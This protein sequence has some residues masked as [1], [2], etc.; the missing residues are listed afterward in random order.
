M[1]CLPCNSTPSLTASASLPQPGL[2]TTGLP[3]PTSSVSFTTPHLDLS[4]RLSL[5]LSPPRSREL[6]RRRRSLS[7]SLSPRGERSRGERSR[8][9]R[10]LPPAAL[11]AG[12]L[13]LLRERSAAAAAGCERERDLLRLRLRSPPPPPRCSSLGAGERERE[14]PR[15]C[16]A[17][18]GQL[19]LAAWVHQAGTPFMSGVCAIEGAIEGAMKASD[20]WMVVSSAGTA[21]PG[22]IG[23]ATC[24]VTSTSIRA[25][26]RQP[27]A[28]NMP[29]PKLHHD[30]QQAWPLAPSGSLCAPHHHFH[31]AVRRRCGHHGPHCE[32]HHP[33]ALRPPALGC[34]RSQTS[35]HCSM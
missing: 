4:L 16:R 27:A 32:A 7:L 28:S 5:S 21:R 9:E 17:G 3:S 8:G 25:S 22:Q 19:G 20:G 31:A 29:R 15:S 10:L 26:V 35:L 13:L 12:D 18:E 14:R 1:T 2:Q 24:R 6:L 30:T 33:S 34:P 11:G 23:K